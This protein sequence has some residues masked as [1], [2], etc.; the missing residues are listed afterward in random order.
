MRL[1]KTKLYLSVLWVFLANVIFCSCETVLLTRLNRLAIG[2]F[3]VLAG[4]ADTGLSVAQTGTLRV[5]VTEIP[6]SLGNPF[7]AMGPP[8]THF[9]GSFYDSLTEVAENGDVVPSLATDWRQTEP[10]NWVFSLQQNVRFHNGAP[11]DARSV[12]ETI[13]YLQSAEAA[14]FLLANE[15]KN[16]LKVRALSD[17]EVEFETREPDAILPRRL[18]LIKLIEPQLWSEL[19]SDVYAHRPVGTGPYAFSNWT[20]GNNV[21]VFV[22]AENSRRIVND[23]NQLTF[24]EVPNAV[25]REQALVSGDLDFIWGLNP[26]SVD[27]LRSTG[28][29]VQV[30]PVSQ[31]VSIALPNVQND[32]SPLQS[33]EVRQALNYAVDRAAIAEHIFGGLVS[34]AS[35]GAMRGTT[36]FNPD[37]TP[38][39]YD[40][41][42]AH[43]LLAVAGYPDGFSFTIGVLQVTGSGQELAYQKVGQDLMAVG[44]AAQVKAVP[45]AEFLRRFMSGDWGEYDAFSLLWNNEP[46]RDVGRALE[47]FSC[48]RPQPFFC[49]KETTD[50]IRASRRESDPKRRNEILQDLMIRVKDLAP[51]IWLT[52]TAHLSASKPEVQDIHLETGAIRFEKIK[53]EQ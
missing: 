1:W 23:V 29:T 9:W 21:A 35:Q 22:A 53:L 31:I 27:G 40:P 49:D 36:G 48:L 38:Y 19:G 2:L 41:E 32:G 16:I 3:F 42:E 45:G 34:V 50:V 33:V 46:M 47:Y 20:N 28:F 5:G 17:Y 15:T 6:T 39:P 10:K 30:Y 13:S 26:D 24:V 4:V 14:R 25:A 8:S 7:T 52:N 37:L 43:R 51:A 44:V 11:F 12:V 18:S